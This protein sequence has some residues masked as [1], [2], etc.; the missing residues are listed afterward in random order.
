MY[1]EG[2]TADAPHHF[3]IFFIKSEIGDL[4]RFSVR[5]CLFYIYGRSQNL[6]TEVRGQVGWRILQFLNNVTNVTYVEKK[7]KLVIK[8][9]LLTFHNIKCNYK[10]D[11]NV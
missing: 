9:K 6:V 10:M 4:V 7:K 3:K 1:T 8:K 5:E 11:K 2:C